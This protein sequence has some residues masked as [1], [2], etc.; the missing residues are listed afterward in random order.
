MFL[1]SRRN[2]NYSPG[3]QTSTFKLNTNSVICALVGGEFNMCNI[4]MSSK[5]KKI[6][7]ELLHMIL[8]YVL[9]HKDFSQSCMSIVSLLYCILNF[10]TAGNSVIIRHSQFFSFFL[11]LHPVL[12]LIGL[13]IIGGEGK[14]I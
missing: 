1:L 4:I 11:Q 7:I 6:R 10:H 12:L 13:I 9:C 2:S 3:F 14:L 5:G 8:S